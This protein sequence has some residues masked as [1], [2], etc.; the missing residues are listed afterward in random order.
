MP[1]PEQVLWPLAPLRLPT[2]FRAFEGCPQKNALDVFDA[3]E[4]EVSVS[5]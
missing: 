5:S 3:R 2:V 4:M 1:P